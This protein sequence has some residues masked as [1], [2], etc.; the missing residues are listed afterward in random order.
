VVQ[1]IAPST[2]FAS[3]ADDILAMVTGIRIQRGSGS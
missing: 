2:T 1:A 3:V